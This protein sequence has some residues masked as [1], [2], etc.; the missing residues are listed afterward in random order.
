[1]LD[2]CQTNFMKLQ[3]PMDILKSMGFDKDKLE[4]FLF[5]FEENYPDYLPH[6][7]IMVAPPNKMILRWDFNDWYV[8]TELDFQKN[9]LKIEAAEVSHR[10]IYTSNNPLFMDVHGWKRMIN[11]IKIVMRK[12]K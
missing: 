8:T 12:S 10:E 1:M 3:V 7:K 4:Q 5:D 9:T 6:P 2:S 11:I